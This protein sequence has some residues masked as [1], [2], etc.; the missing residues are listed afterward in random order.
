[1]IAAA[2][3]RRRFLAGTAACL[4]AGIAGAKTPAAPAA[5]SLGAWTSL[6]N[7]AL[8]ASS[9]YG[10]VEEEVDRFLLPDKPDTAFEAALATARAAP[11][12]V[13]TL[14][15]LLPPSLQSVGPDTA[16]DGIVT[17]CETVFARARRAGVETV[18][19]GSPRSRRIPEGFPRATAE[20]QLIE[21]CKRLG[22]VA[23][24]HGV[25]LAL[26]PLNHTETNFINRV[27]E[28]G[29][30]V[31]AVGHPSVG[32]VADLFH[33]RMEDEGPASLIENGPLIRHVQIAEKQGR[34]APGVAGEDFSA[35]FEALRSIGYDRRLSVECLWSD[36]A[37]EAPLAART[38]RAQYPAATAKA[39]RG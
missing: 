21:L 22:P 1:M 6:D 14:V 39:A 2:L 34:R 3:D 28:G 23:Q 27:S 25:I 37:R 26:E 8:L 32:L 15:R 13:R 4:A 35:Y 12:P 20:A 5:P 29:A 11:I 36:I 9:G 16:H 19:F 17:F 7:A 18:V 30:I 38:I 31:R 24:A 10:F 33:M